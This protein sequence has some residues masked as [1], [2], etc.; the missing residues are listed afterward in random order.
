MNVSVF[1]LL[2]GHFA[3][4]ASCL[5]GLQF[6]TITHISPT[7]FFF[8]FS[9]LK[10]FGFVDTGSLPVAFCQYKFIPLFSDFVFLFTL[11]RSLSAKG[12]PLISFPSLKYPPILP[13]I[14][15]DGKKNGACRRGGLERRCGGMEQLKREDGRLR[16]FNVNQR[17]SSRHGEQP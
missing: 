12:P 14:T 2:I 9:H 10:L 8:L 15:Q 4:M 6:C 16:H 3:K 1:L 17:H 5:A 13:S 11:I 7:V